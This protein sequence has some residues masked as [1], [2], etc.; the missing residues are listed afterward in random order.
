MKKLM[1]MLMAAV[2]AGAATAGAEP[3]G[4][5]SG[6]D[7][8][9]IEIVD[10]KVLLGVSVCTNGDLT[11]ETESWGAAKLDPTAVEQAEDGKGLVIPVPAT[12]EQGFMI[13]KSKPTGKQG[14]VSLSN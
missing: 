4:A 8:E 5:V 12:A 2:A 3:S 13:L 1:M 14:R 11:A 7:P 6:A 10:G 9:R